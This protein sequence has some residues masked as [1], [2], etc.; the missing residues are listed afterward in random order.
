[1]EDAVTTE[2]LS[3]LLKNR[4]KQQQKTPLKKEIEK[5]SLLGTDNL[6][7]TLFFSLVLMFWGY[8]LVNE[9][10]IFQSIDT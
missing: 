10:G 9:N 3:L 7:V 8:F 4:T 1:M 2:L 6:I 5:L